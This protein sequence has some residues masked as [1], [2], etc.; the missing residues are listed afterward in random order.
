MKLFI[1]KI[2]KKVYK[3]FL[4]TCLFFFIYDFHEIK[5]QEQCGFGQVMQPFFSQNTNNLFKSS[6]SSNVNCD[7]CS[8]IFQIPLVFH[9]L[10]N[11][12]SENISDSQIIQAVY[13]LNDQFAGFE[14]GYETGI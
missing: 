9:V 3:S 5:C 7:T 14:G 13:Q 2:P 8:G 12:G 4:S 1:R 10:H 11:N 6:S